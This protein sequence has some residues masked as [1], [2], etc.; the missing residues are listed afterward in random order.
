MKIITTIIKKEL[1]EI[2]R[3]K[4]VLISTVVLPLI[5][6]P[7]LFIGANK[8]LNYFT[9]SEL[10]KKD[11]LYIENIKE[12]PLLETLFS[13]ANFELVKDVKHSDIDSLINEEALSVA[14]LLPKN[15]NQYFQ[16]KKTVPIEF[17]FKSSNLMIDKKVTAV[18][19]AYKNQVLEQR[20]AE[21]H[22]TKETIEP[23]EL[24]RNDIATDKEKYGKIIG[25][26]I[27]YMFIILGFMGCIYSAIDL[28]AGEKERKTIETL[29]TFPI[30]RMKILIGKFSVI[31]ITGLISVLISFLGMFLATQLTNM[32]SFASIIS[33]DAISGLDIVLVILLLIP[34]LVFFAGILS[35]I[36]I[37]SKTYKEAMS[38]AGQLNFIVLIPAFISM[39]PGVELNTKTVFIPVLNVA[40]AI[41]DIF[42]GTL[43]YQMYTLVIFSLI[44]FAGISV[45]F[46]KNKFESE[47]SLLS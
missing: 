46:S 33:I 43:D 10:E 15:T 19:E 41:K 3:D 39:L 35:P 28:F 44:V 5:L 21:L 14:L 9:Q 42:S 7:L 34:L 11:K 13:Q 36:S 24:V 40:L 31:V 27:P 22:I 37:Y 25:G 47:T 18:F 29:L 32:E 4:K 2:F 30:S 6:F 23:V 20:L 12:I 16:Q 38:M 45:W 26:L 8:A 17:R 1:T